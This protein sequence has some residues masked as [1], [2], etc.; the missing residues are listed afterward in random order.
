MIQLT[1]IACFPLVVACRRVG[2]SLQHGLGRECFCNTSRSITF[3]RTE[4][5]LSASAGRDIYTA[6]D[7]Y[8][9]QAAAAAAA[10]WQTWCITLCLFYC[11]GVFRHLHW[12]LPTFR[13]ARDFTHDRLDMSNIHCNSQRKTREFTRVFE[14]MLIFMDIWRVKFDKFDNISRP[15]P[16]FNVIWRWTN[17]ML[18]NSNVHNLRHIVVTVNDVFVVLRL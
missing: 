2:L 14:N 17:K 6:I 12:P 1:S 13:T 10:A 3:I 7:R 4:Y 11:I 16:Y 15:P 9:A 5:W 18:S 8:N